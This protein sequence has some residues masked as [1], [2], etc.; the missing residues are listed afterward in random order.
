M[1]S[2]V[3][4]FFP[5][6]WFIWVTTQTKPT[7][8]IWL[9]F[10]SVTQSYL[11]HWD[12]VDYSL[13]GSSVSLEFSRQEH[14]SGLPFPSS[15]DLPD[16]GIEPMSLAS[17]AIARGFSTTAPPGKPLGFS[18]LRSFSPITIPQPFFFFFAIYLLNKWDHLS[19]RVSQLP[20]W[21]TAFQVWPNG[22]LCAL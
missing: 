8:G 15:G 17:P 5:H 18:L 12:P 2:V 4:F 6:S 22:L 14:W 10:S 13:P 19:G 21:W 7:C 3:F 1:L 11:T 20:N 9:L 16:S